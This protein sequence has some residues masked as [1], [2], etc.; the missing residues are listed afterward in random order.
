MRAR[1][2]T[3]HFSADFAPAPDFLPRLLAR[4]TE[5]ASVHYHRFA[6]SNSALTRKESREVHLH[7]TRL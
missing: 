2:L 4:V 5:H 6:A 7:S 3:R 1:A